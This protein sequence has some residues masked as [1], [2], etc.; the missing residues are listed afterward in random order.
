MIIEL[1]FPKCKRYIKGL[2]TPWTMDFWI[3]MTIFE[4]PYKTYEYELLSC[5]TCITFMYSKLW[6]IA[7]LMFNKQKMHWINGICV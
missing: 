2:N 6:D 3:L 1:T 5:A 7:S 4:R